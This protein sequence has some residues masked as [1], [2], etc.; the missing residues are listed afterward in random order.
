MLREQFAALDRDV[1]GSRLAYLDNASTTQR[2]EAVLEAITRFYRSSNANVH[3]GVHTLSVEATDAYE[4]AR[5]RVARF[6]GADDPRAI[7]FVRGTT[8]AINLVANAFAP[9]VVGPGDEVLVSALEHHS[10]LVPWQM[11]CAR[12]GAKLTVIPLDDRGDLVLDHFDRIDERTKIVAVSH[13]SNSLGTVNDVAAIVRAAKS[14]GA[15]TVV[16]GAQAVGHQR[17][18]VRALDCDFYAFSSHKMYGPMGIG[19]LYARRAL[20]ES[21][22]PWQ[23]GGD[24][25]ND[26][27]FEAT[28]YNE[29]PYRFEAGTPNVAGAVGLAAAMDFLDAASIDAVAAH[30]RRLIEHTVAALRSLP[31][32][33]L[34][35]APRRRASA[36]SFVVEGVHPHDV[37]TVL[38]THGIA[39]RAGHHCAQPAME[40]FGVAATV[41]ASFAM[42]NE[43]EEVDRMVAAL[44]DVRGIFS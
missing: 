15:I 4:A 29:V 14:V 39:V 25:V 33:R 3:R 18:D 27:T 26:V 16:D 36:V 37:G 19:A 28:T 12:T 44:E 5:G 43:V 2:P 7:V 8:E 9:T 38:D 42:Y 22:P 35:G 13:V 31:N 11:L 6:L 30:E 1:G 17:V 40:H 20:L 21:M 32:V 41:R 34:I 10:N 24:M 23:G